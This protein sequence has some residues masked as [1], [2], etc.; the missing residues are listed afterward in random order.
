M[1]QN[2]SVFAR[3]IA[4]FLEAAA[5][6][7]IGVWWRARHPVVGPGDLAAQLVHGFAHYAYFVV[8][9]PWGWMAA[10]LFVEGIVRVLAA[11]MQQPLGTAPVALARGLWA[12]RPAKK[13]PDDVVTA[14]DDGFVIDS[15]RDYDWHALTTV[16]LDGAHYAVARGA[17]TAERPL[18]YRLTPIA[19]DHVI[20]A[21]ARYAPTSARG[22]SA[23][24]SRWPRR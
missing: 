1:W 5:G 8:A 19:P 12:L 4:G 2:R 11:A 24:T 10:W 23:R 6:L 20:R 17:G 15:A 22:G 21:V 7:A 14:R 3:L 18:R 16:E 13:L 9:T